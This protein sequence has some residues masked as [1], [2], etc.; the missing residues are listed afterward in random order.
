MRP[1][2][3]VA[4][5]PV[6]LWCGRRRDRPQARKQ[7]SQRGGGAA[8]AE[9]RGP[10]AAA[11]LGLDIEGAYRGVPCWNGA[12]RWAKQVVPVAYDLGYSAIRARLGKNPVSRRAVLAVAAARAAY[13]DHATGREC[14]PTDAQLAADTGLSLR[15][16]T[17]ASTCLRLLGVA[18]EVLRGRQRTLDERMAAWRIGDSA[19]GW[20]SVWALH[21]N[22]TLTR[23]V[24]LATHLRS[25]PVRDKKLLKKSL[26]TRSA[27]PSGPRRRAGKRRSAPDRGGLG[28]ARSW[29][30]SPHA[31]TWAHRYRAE[32]W[33]AIL[34]APAASGWTPRDL[35]QLVVDYRGVG[36]RVPEE[37]YKPIGLLAAMIGWHGLDSLDQR[38]AVY[39][40]A[41][42]DAAAA[43]RQARIAAQHAQAQ[44][45]QRQ[46][47]QRRDA[48][49]CPGRLAAREAARQ[50]TRSAHA[51]RTAQAAAEHRHLQ[52]QIQRARGG[53]Q[54]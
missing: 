2:R 3:G 39:D 26:S 16:V 49:P 22:Q 32:A 36:R 44:H 31:P 46:R 11:S 14:R 10:L 48:P 18:T 1:R 25:G 42:D 45:H 50:A 47:E 17:A 12:A 8:G 52:T 30:S 54:T 13:A 51:K 27:C 53:T 35:N 23:R 21:D 6:G 33:A 15:T 34:A 20:A 9:R 40:Q 38:P 41:R 37:P 24:E 43:A 29:R 19:R 28:L 5:M 7:S 4:R